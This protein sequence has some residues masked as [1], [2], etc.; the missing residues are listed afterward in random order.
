MQIHLPFSSS[1]SLSAIIISESVSEY[2][3]N[4][5]SLQFSTNTLSFS[6]LTGWP[7]LI[8]HKASRSFLPQVPT[9]RASLSLLSASLPSPPPARHQNPLFA[10]FINN[11][12]SP[13]ITKF[14]IIK[15]GSFFYYLIW[16]GVNN[17]N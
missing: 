12:L 1:H 5:L 3:H 11:F 9:A 17:K 15:F 16:V 7:F 13:P 2:L 10:F 8:W 4:K 14:I 6:L